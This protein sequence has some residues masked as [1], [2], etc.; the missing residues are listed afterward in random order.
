MFNLGPIGNKRLSLKNVKFIFSAIS[1]ISLYLVTGLLYGQSKGNNQLPTGIIPMPGIIYYTRIPAY[2]NPSSSYSKYKL[3]FN[4]KVASFTGIRKDIKEYYFDTWYQFKKSTGFAV[5]VQMYDNQ[6]GPYIHF[7]DFKLVPKYTFSLSSKT[8][9]STAVGVGF[10][11]YAF[12]GNDVIAGGS[13]IVSDVDFGSIIRNENWDFGIA[14]KHLLNQTLRPIVAE[15]RKNKTVN[16]HGSKIF[17]LSPDFYIHPTI[18][19][20]LH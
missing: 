4:S 9:V 19:T 8:Q 20:N 17:K 15:F 5:G 2:Y 7:M 10:L 16:I 18:L 11:N 13:D 1:S 6:Q 12:K 3:A 14:V